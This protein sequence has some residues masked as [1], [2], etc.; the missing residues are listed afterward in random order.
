MKLTSIL[1]SERLIKESRKPSSGIWYYVYLPT[2]WQR[3]SYKYSEYPPDGHEAFW[4]RYIVPLLAKAYKLDDAKAK[5]LESAYR[6]FPRGRVDLSASKDGLAF[7]GEKPNTWYFFHGNDFPVQPEAEKSRLVDDFNLTGFAIRNMVEFKHAVH[8]EMLP[9]HR[10]I[11]QKI[12][13]LS[14]DGGRL[15][16][17]RPFPRKSWNESSMQWI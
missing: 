1:K 4:K 7:A 6:G 12:L 17:K 2:G 8:E 16:K 3:R 9:D 11:V 15:V 10:A 13:G 5:K 14:G